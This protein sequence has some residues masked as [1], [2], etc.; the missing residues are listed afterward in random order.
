MWAALGFLAANLL[1]DMRAATAVE[2]A[3]L[4]S[5][6]VGAAMGGMIA[7]GLSLD[8]LFTSLSGQ[9]VASTPPPPPHRCVEVGS[10]CPK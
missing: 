6:I 5:L 7:F 2:Y 8:L 1:A 9:V 10:N 4:V 3:L